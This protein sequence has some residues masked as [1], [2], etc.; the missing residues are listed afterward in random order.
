MSRIDLRLRNSELINLMASCAIIKVDTI[1]SSICD[2]VRSSFLVY[3]KKTQPNLLQAT[4]FKLIGLATPVPVLKVKCRMGLGSPEWHKSY[5]YYI[6][7]STCYI[8]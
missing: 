2:V 1:I 3:L 6:M 8:H 4:V 5:K 7:V